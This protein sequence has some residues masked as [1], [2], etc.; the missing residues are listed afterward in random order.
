MRFDSAEL[1]SDFCFAASVTMKRLEMSAT[2]PTSSSVAGSMSCSHMP[3]PTMSAKCA[4]ISAANIAP[5]TTSA[6]PACR[7]GSTTMR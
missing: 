3:A 7:R 4:T 6:G 2:W 5:E 1:S